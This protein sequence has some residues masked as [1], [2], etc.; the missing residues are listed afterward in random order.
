VPD[1]PNLD[2]LAP[3]AARLATSREEFVFVGGAVVG[4]LLT[5][6]ASDTPR[7]TDDV[8]VIVQVAG[9][10]DYQLRLVP[11]LR[12]LGFQE[13]IEATTLC[14]WLLDG[15]RVDVMPTDSSILGFSNR[16]YPAAIGTAAAMSIGGHRVRVITAPSF[17]ATKL[18]AFRGRGGGDH[19]GSHDLEDILA[20]VD[21]RPELLGEIT[22]ASPDL[23]R[24]IAGEIA[25]VL[26]SQDFLNALPGHTRD[27]GRAGILLRRLHALAA[28]DG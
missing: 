3:V 9:P 11:E 4:L 27:R 18:E 19:Y 8:D 17:I 7:P 13:D 1:D 23:R 16:W 15:T 10:A 6:P 26:A 28:L 25:A 14:R 21:G 12:R 22:A 5:D 20:V 24:Y 2:L